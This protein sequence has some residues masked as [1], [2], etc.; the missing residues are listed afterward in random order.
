MS[1]IEAQRVMGYVVATLQADPQLATSIGGR[2]YRDRVPAGAALPAVTVSLVA[3]T[4]VLT[5]GADRVIQGVDLDVRVVAEGVS[6]TPVNGPADRI[7]AVLANRVGTRDGVQIVELRRTQVQSYV[8]DEA[9]K[10][11]V[12]LV[13]TYH[14]ESHAIS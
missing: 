4:D 9:G 13:T 2:V 8:E 3:A 5:L 10:A 11:Y 7:D 1:V 14:T 6:Y 12:H